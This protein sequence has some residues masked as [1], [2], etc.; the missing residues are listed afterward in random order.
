VQIQLNGEMRTLDRPLTLAELVHELELSPQ[1][2]AVEI[3]APLVR[4]ADY[5]ETALRDG[6]RVE[7]VTLVGGG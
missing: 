6:D 3:N 7:V 5:A 1:R 4:R 2:I